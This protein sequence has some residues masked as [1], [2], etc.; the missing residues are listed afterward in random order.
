[1]SD[2]NDFVSSVQSGSRQVHGSKFYC[3]DGV[4]EFKVISAKM[5]GVWTRGNSKKK[6]LEAYTEAPQMQHIHVYCENALGAVAN[7]SLAIGQVQYYGGADFLDVVNPNKE[8]LQYVLQEQKE[9]KEG[10]RAPKEGTKI[11]IIGGINSR[12]FRAQIERNQGQDGFRGFYH[13]IKVR[14]SDKSEAIKAIDKN[15]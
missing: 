8:E 12:F 1:M 9:L 5:R 13:T 15:S 10:Q 4:H 6:G 2:L 7:L 11:Y 14:R 3:Q